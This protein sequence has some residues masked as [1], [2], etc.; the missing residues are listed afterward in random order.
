MTL[1]LM[2]T[3]I[4]VSSAVAFMNYAIKHDIK[5]GSYT[6]YKKFDKI[7][8]SEEEM[9]TNGIKTNKQEKW[10]NNAFTDHIISPGILLQNH[11]NGNHISISVSYL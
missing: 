7:S 10:N 2:L 4:I 5:V 11:A 9:L 1:I 8:S 6:F 3:F